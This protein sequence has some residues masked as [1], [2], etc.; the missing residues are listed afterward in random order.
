MAS[1]SK[2]MVVPI[3]S[4]IAAGDDATRGF[5]QR[6]FDLVMKFV[7]GSVLIEI[8]PSLAYSHNIVI[9]IALSA[10][11]ALML[12]YLCF[13][14]V[15]NEVTHKEAS[16]HATPRFRKRDKIRYYATRFGRK[17]H[18]ITDKLNKIKSQEARRALI[19]S[20]VKK[21]F[22]IPDEST[23]VTLNRYRLPESFFEPDEDED[24]SYPEDLKLMIS[25]IRVFGH[26][27]KSLLMDF[28]KFIKTVNLKT[29]EYLFRIGQRDENVYVVRTGRIQLDAR[30]SDGSE[31]ILSEVTRGGSIDSF[32]SVLKVLTG[33]PCLYDT[34]EAVALEDSSVLMLPIRSFLE[35]CRPRTP[36]LMRILQMITVRLQRLTALAIQ[37]QLGLFSELIK[38][39]SVTC[40]GNS[41]AKAYLLSLQ[42][43]RMSTQ[44]SSA[45]VCAGADSSSGRP[46]SVPTE[47]DLPDRLIEG[48]NSCDPVIDDLQN[49]FNSEDNLSPHQSVCGGLELGEAPSSAVKGAH[50][51]LSSPSQTSSPA[52]NRQYDYLTQSAPVESSSSTGVME[53]SGLNDQVSPNDSLPG[54]SAQCPTLDKE[55]EPKLLAAVRDDIGLLLN[56]PDSSVLDGHVTL[57]SVPSG[58]VLSHESEMQNDLYYVVSGGLC[59]SKSAT[60]IG[61][62]GVCSLF[63]C[64]P[65]DVIG[66]LGLISGETNNYSI[67]TTA[68]SIV[69]TLSRDY[70]Y[71]IVRQNPSALINAIRLINARVSPL[72]HQ[73]DFAIQWITLDAGKALFK[74]GDSAEHL[75]VVLSGR[76]R[77]VD[78]LPDGRR[79]IV[80]ELGRGDLVG[81]LEVVCSQSR[82]YTVIAIRDSEVARVPA[83]LMQHLRE[84]VPQVLSRIVRL[85]SNKLLGNMTATQGTATGLDLGLPGI[86]NSIGYGGISADS[87]VDSTVTRSTMSNV[88]TIA[89]LPVTGVINAEAFTLELQHSMTPIGSSVRL[90]SHIVKRRLG[91]GALDSV[92]QYRLNAWLSHQEDLHR[93]VFFVCSCSR[94]S[95]WNR[96]CIRQADCVLVLAL[97]NAD[98]GRLS[99]VELMLMNHPTKASKVLVLMYPLDTDYPRRGQ[100]AKWLNVRPW[101]SHHYHIRCEPRVFTPRS[102]EDL[103][104]FYSNVFAKEHANPLSDISRLARYLTGEAIG[105]VLGGGGARGCAHVGVI[106]AFQDLGIPI[107]LIGG[108]SMGAFMSALW[109]DETR[110]AQFTQ[111]AR[112]LTNSL[113]STWKRLKDFTYPVV[114]VFSGREFNEQL[115]KVFDDRQVEDLWLP[116]F[117][118]T[119]D[120]TNCKMRVHVQ[121]SLWR[122]VRASMT[123]SGYF[124]PMCDPYDGSML[125]DGGYMNNLPADIMASFGAKTIFAV[126]VG[127]T[128]D[129]DFTNYGDHLSGWNLLYHRF[130]KS[131]SGMRVP[132]LTEIQTRLAYISCVKQ[133]EQV[134]NSGLYH[135]MRPPIDRFMTLQFAA[136]DEIMNVGCEY[137]KDM[138]RRWHE[139]GVL[140]QMVPGLRHTPFL[141]QSN[142]TPHRTPTKP[143]TPS[144]DGAKSEG[145]GDWLIQ[146]FDERRSFVD[147]AETLSR[148][149]S[150]TRSRSSDTDEES[151]D[152]FTGVR[153]RSNR[154]LL[155]HIMPVHSTPSLNASASAAAYD[156]EVGWK[157][158]ILAQDKS[159][160]VPSLSKA[161]YSCLHSASHLLSRTFPHTKFFRRRALSADFDVSG[162]SSLLDSSDEAGHYSDAHE[163]P[164]NDSHSSTNR[165]L[166]RYLSP[167]RIKSDSSQKQQTNSSNVHRNYRDPGRR[168]SE[169]SQSERPLPP[170]R[171]SDGN[172]LSQEV[173]VSSSVPLS[174]TNPVDEE[175]YM[176]D[177]ESDDEAGLHSTIVS[178]PEMGVHKVYTAHHLAA[179]GIASR[180]A[181]SDRA[182][183]QFDLMTVC[184][185]ECSCSVEDRNRESL[186]MSFRSYDA[187]C[188]NTSTLPPTRNRRLR[189]RASLNRLRRQPKWSESETPTT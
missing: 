58:T 24:T 63:R 161:V 99:P 149:N 11:L 122:Y 76:L 57:A 162:E 4:S 43:G 154:T 187:E 80:S 18:N 15:K 20:F 110:F 123:L 179:G 75:F 130:F 3:F 114:S 163:C 95:T 1:A 98:P 33:V 17:F 142:G 170:H 137:T 164:G 133:L 64:G 183:N 39:D 91:S 79:R 83:A 136:F 120:I 23:S 97:G 112:N 72:L 48:L 66:F 109:A 158:F 56:L 182:L 16:S 50:P 185:G 26:L 186:S 86:P 115:K 37:N 14:H 121:G 152:Y 128:V 89:I 27:E 173:T 167:P 174:N 25:S 32:V 61:D 141:S 119:T 138:F 46:P 176:E 36:P 88:R 134:K 143:S 105:L 2:E 131:N 51:L 30:D 175:G 59:A 102:P 172:L 107:D 146:T 77:M 139:E 153:R 108:T 145:P 67:K 71:T 42:E 184:P 147:L 159:K 180:L 150:L 87:K 101:I 45:E 168:E 52:D 41:K 189:R 125:V 55:S 9:L 177:I 54:E 90:T 104:A 94:T 85:L 21:I 165:L 148:G 106:R 166:C 31:F 84:K 126:D 7:T 49:E 47:G 100:T 35:V 53:Q 129:T 38:Q 116:S 93:I 188:L 65:G 117:Y 118:V 28:C 40:E 156:N 96:L 22:N 157:R 178:E 92:N 124:P 155:S 160:Y 68:N 29:G 111:R 78:T 81:L 82:I 10:A 113:N 140:R 135:Y 44:S 60:D 171:H 6:T 69:A 144:P 19:I 181:R 5:L 13:R 62:K 169:P 74:K 8:F 73:L 132:N 12:L 127:A 103:V 151:S 34:L 70:F